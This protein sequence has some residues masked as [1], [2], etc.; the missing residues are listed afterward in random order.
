MKLKLLMWNVDGVGGIARELRDLVQRMRPD[1]VLGSE[2]KELTVRGLQDAWPGA[3][4]EF[5][6]SSRKSVGAAP[7]AGLAM[8][9]KSDLMYSVSYVY[10]EGCAETNSFI[11]SIPIAWEHG[12]HV[13]GTY[14][15]PT[16]PGLHI[17]RYLERMKEVNKGKDLLLGDL[18]ARHVRWDTTTKV[19]GR[20]L[21]RCTRGSMLRVVPPQRPTYHPRGRAGYSTPYLALSNIPNL[22]LQLID[23]GLWKSTSDRSPVVWVCP[24]AVTG[25][26]REGKRISKAALSNAGRDKEEGCGKRYRQIAPRLIKL[27]K[28]AKEQD[29]QTVFSQ[30]TTELVEP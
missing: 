17:N 13:T 28:E 7:R 26:R 2:V 23:E 15:S 29:A 8:L 10:N 16:T 18:N 20:A 14:V 12:I 19:R 21:L 24:D 25:Q 5:I 11:Q 6:P 9:I 4:T 27:L 22:E 1:V 30:V 3:S